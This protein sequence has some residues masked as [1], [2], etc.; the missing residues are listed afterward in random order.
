MTAYHLLGVS[1]SELDNSVDEAWKKTF[2]IEPVKKPIPARIRA[3]VLPGPIK[4]PKR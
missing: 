1:Q 4:R 2:D 3:N